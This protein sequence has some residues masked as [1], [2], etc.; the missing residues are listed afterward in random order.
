MRILALVQ[1][2][3]ENYSIQRL[4]QAFE[5]RGDTFDMV[6][7]LDCSVVVGENSKPQVVY[8]DE[9]LTGYDLV[10]PRVAS[11]TD[12]GIQVVRVM[13]TAVASNL[14][15]SGSVS[16]NHPLAKF[17]AH[18]KFFTIQALAGAGVPVPSTVLTWDS[19][20]IAQLVG[21][22]WGVPI[23]LKMLE[24]TWGMGVMRADSLEAAVS[25]FEALQGTGRLLTAQ[26]YI[27][28]SA[29]RDIRVIVVGDQVIGAVRRIAPEGEFRANIHRGA[30]SEAIDLAKEDQDLALRAARALELEIAG[31][32]M[33]ETDQG[34]QVI[35]VNPAPGFKAIEESLGIDA[36][37]PIARY[38]AD[39]VVKS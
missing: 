32:D 25:T 10:L 4:R 39:R 35:E 8:Q 14:M 21:Q 22:D 12:F 30:I 15:M 18:N 29:G 26:R 23:I 13:E 27:R 7:P 33:L 2:V 16:V 34:L 5:A 36:A 38:L 20:Y 3:V 17:R 31:V 24:G 9:E 1:K 6:N 19:D 37:G 28:E 11:F